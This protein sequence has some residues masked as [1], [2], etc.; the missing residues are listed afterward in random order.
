MD[1]VYKTFAQK[2]DVGI[3]AFTKEQIEDA[4]GQIYTEEPVDPYALELD[5]TFGKSIDI[6]YSGYKIAKNINVKAV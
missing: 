2:P 6:N 5:K 3:A 1:S 4:E